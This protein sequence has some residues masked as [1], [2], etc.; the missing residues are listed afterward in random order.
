MVSGLFS[1]LIINISAQNKVWTE[2]NQPQKANV[3]S[4]V[5]QNYINISSLSLNER[6]KAFTDL[7]AEG[8]AIFLKLH[9]ALQLI[10]HSNFSKDQRE[11]ILEGIALITPD[12]YNRTKNKGEFELQAQSLKSR[13]ESLFTSQEVTD[14]FE[15]LGGDSQDAKIIQKYQNII[16]LTSFPERKIAFRKMSPTDMSNLWKVQLAFYLVKD[17]ELNN[18]QKEFIVRVIDTI[19]P[20]L[21]KFYK[22]ADEKSEPNEKIQILESESSTLFSEQ[23]AL[24][25]PC[26]RL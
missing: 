24:T 4:D 2:N 5:L 3:E 25:I 21:Y 17:N 20:A 14:I 12:S 23:K 10:K 8:K 26:V 7:S 18:S 19:T 1:L 9:L 13:A 22:N 6:R 15:R 16:G 11:L